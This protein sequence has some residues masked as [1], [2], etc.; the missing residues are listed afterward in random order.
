MT[1]ED[2]SDFEPDIKAQIQ[3]FTWSIKD[4]NT[5]SISLDVIFANPQ[6]FGTLNYSQFLVVKAKFSDFEPDWKDDAA[7]I[8]GYLDRMQPANLLLTVTDRGVQTDRQSRWF[9]TPHAT[10]SLDAA[11]LAAAAARAAVSSA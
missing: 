9:A 11:V 2:E 10:R 1:I 5:T 8:R 3:D 6:H 4:A 7:L